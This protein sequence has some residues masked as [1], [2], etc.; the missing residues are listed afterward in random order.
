[1]VNLHCWKTLQN[2]KVLF[3][4]CFIFCQNSSNVLNIFF[5]QLSFGSEMTEPCKAFVLVLKHVK[6]IF[7]PKVHND[8]PWFPITEIIHIF[9]G[10]HGEGHWNTLGSLGIEH[11]QRISW[12]SLAKG[13]QALAKVSPKAVSV[14]EGTASSKGKKQMKQG[15]VQKVTHYLSSESWDTEAS[16]VFWLQDTKGS[17]THC[18]PGSVWSFSPGC[19][20]VPR[21]ASSCRSTAS[22]RPDLPWGV[23]LCH[24]SCL[25][26]AIPQARFLQ[27]HLRSPLKTGTR[28]KLQACLLMSCSSEGLSEIVC[29][30]RPHQM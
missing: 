4:K 18:K 11:V 12:M 1:M 30:E 24:H 26:C 28:A 20:V 25:W 15:P 7:T 2:F 6:S 13:V 29:W 9:T 22:L 27:N 14:M 17:F 10:C 5:K 21:R 16:G 3:I 23:T 8:V 19:K